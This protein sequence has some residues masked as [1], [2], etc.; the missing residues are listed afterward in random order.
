M[1]DELEPE[2]DTDLLMAD[3]EEDEKEEDPLTMGF[4]E[5]GLE[6]DTDF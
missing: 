6:P 2:H 1:D 3:E 4:H 5:E